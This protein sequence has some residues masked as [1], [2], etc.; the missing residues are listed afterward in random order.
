MAF[1]LLKKKIVCS[2]GSTIFFSL[3]RMHL[4]NSGWKVIYLLNEFYTPQGLDILHQLCKIYPK[5]LVCKGK[6]S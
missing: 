4:H 5:Y 1:I 6:V 3:K 2:H